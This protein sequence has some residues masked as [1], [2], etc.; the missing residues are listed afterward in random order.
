LDQLSGHGPIVIYASSNLLDWRPIFTNPPL[1]GSLQFI[2]SSATN[3]QVQFYR[4]VEE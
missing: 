3:S 2:D 1:P 4:A